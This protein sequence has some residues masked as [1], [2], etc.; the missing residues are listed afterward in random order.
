MIVFSGDVG[1][2][3]TRMQLTEFIGSDDGSTSFQDCKV[4]I[5]KREQYHNSDYANFTDVIDAFFL[6]TDSSTKTKI[7]SACFGV[8][9]PIINETVKVTNLPW[10]IKAE[11]IKKKLG[12]E[13]VALINDFM[14]IGYGL[15]TLL[16]QD[17][18]TLQVGK[19]CRDGVKSYIGAGTGLGV[20]FMFCKNGICNVCPTEG[21]HVDFAPA[22]ETQLKLLQFL[23]KKY[24]HVSFELVLSGMGLVNIYRFVRSQKS[25]AEEENHNLAILLDNEEHR[26]D[27]AATVFEYAV[28]QNDV[29]AARALDIF[30]RIY[31]AAV[32]NLALTTLPF[33]GLYI[34]GGIAPKLL[35]QIQNRV[36]LEAFGNKGRMSNL[37]KD[38]PLHVVLCTN[39]GLQGTALYAKNIA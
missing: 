14:A 15:E 26:A 36:F 25:G 9:G 29:L 37:I 4:N 33:G 17:L 5:I 8:A 1:G 23:S 24:H 3:S 6:A 12:I 16:P 32:G 20:G 30:I 22:D 2:T 13:R 7:K 10:V 31:G 27:I 38:I 18:L 19:P 28:R 34:V 39:V 35:S 21:G 11:E